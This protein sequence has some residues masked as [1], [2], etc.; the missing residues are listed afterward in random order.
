MTTT[1]KTLKEPKNISFKEGGFYTGI[2]SRKTPETILLLMQRIAKALALQGLVLRSGGANGA[3]AAFEIGCNKVNG[4]K[5]IFL[6]WSLFNNNSSTLYTPMPKAFKIAK[7]FHP[8]WANCPPA[9]QSLHARNIHQVLGKDLKTPSSF[10]IYWAETKKK[11]GQLH[12]VPIGG[13]ATAVKLA[14]SIGVPT[15]NLYHIE[16][17]KHWENLLDLPY[18][19]SL[20]R[21]PNLQKRQKS[22]NSKPNKIP[23]LT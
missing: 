13:T 12:P 10:V 21:L 1:K 3:D 18:L 7:D 9:S 11:I 6:P 5:E 2:G 15:F 17:R 8:R 14:E 23:P 20:Q 19:Q 4:K 16:I 22:I